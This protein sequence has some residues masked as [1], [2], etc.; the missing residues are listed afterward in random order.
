ML[1][2][3]SILVKL[4]RANQPKYQLGASGWERKG[5]SG[6]SWIKRQA[7]TR[8]P[9]IHMRPTSR[10]GFSLFLAIACTGISHA[11]TLGIIFEDTTHTGQFGPGNVPLSGVLVIVTNTSGT[12]L[13]SGFSSASRG[14]FAIDLGTSTDTY[15]EFLEP[16]TLPAGAV[17]ELPAGGVYTFT[18]GPHNTN[19]LGN[20]LVRTGTSPPPQP[21]T[22]GFVFLDVNQT[23]QFGSNDVGVPGV[24]VVVTNTSGTFS[25]AVSTTA[26]GGS[27]S[28]Q[29]GTPTDT[30]V[31]FLVSKTLP[32]GGVVE[33]PAGRVYTFSPGP[34]RTDFEGNFLVRKT[35]S[36]PPELQ[37]SGFVLLD[38]NQTGQFESNDVGVPGVLVVVTN[39]SGTFSNVSVTTSP[40]GGFSIPLAS[41][42]DKYTEYVLP[43]SLPAGTNVLIPSERLYTFSLGTNQVFGGTFLIGSRAHT[44]APQEHTEGLVLLDVNH[45]GQFEGN[46]LGLPNVLVVV[47]NLS[48][49]F[50]NASLTTASGGTFSIQ[51]GSTTDT[52]VEYLMPA[53]LPTG[54]FVAQPT[55]GAY[56]FDLGPS[57]LEFK[58]NFLVGSPIS[59]SVPGTNN[60]SLEAHGT[61]N[62]QNKGHAQF[63]FTGSAFSA[64]DANNGA[65]GE[66]NIQSRDPR[67]TF[68]GS[69][70]DILNCGELT[71]SSGVVTRYIDFQ[72]AGNLK[73]SHG[74]KTHYGVVT[75][76]GRAVDNGHSRQHPDSLYF[77]VD[78]ADGNTVLLISGDSSD[79]TDVE[80]VTLSS[81]E[82][83][84]D[85]NSSQGQG[86]EGND[87]GQ[88]NDNGNSDHGRGHNHQ[89]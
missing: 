14:N 70:F 17:V 8:N 34:N 46:D 21:K 80:P 40:S 10:L 56:T 39:A 12:F 76:S 3:A 5:G 44:N 48:G 82:I 85:T 67:L 60:C 1:V 19:F 87:D 79:P 72:G 62:G 55:G 83:T 11:N 43:S 45:T 7:E 54:S 23:G 28:M 24:L 53:S 74:A 77:R 58:G 25:N 65:T 29:L 78:T 73:G 42:S 68:S 13:A 69:V 32:A 27:F 47:T 6:Q 86:G 15:V 66:W 35:G 71:N 37:A 20:F 26:P 59:P 30:Y 22:S 2:F 61:I 9:F 52:Y 16:M 18:P 84:I 88:G 4:S 50:S 31:E 33:L 57:N 63:T 81:G 64:R 49:T 51:L 41:S 38:V 36:T 75:F 89:N